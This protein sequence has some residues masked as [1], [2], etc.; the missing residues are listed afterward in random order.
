LHSGSASAL[1]GAT[2]DP[3]PNGDSSLYQTVTIPSSG[4]P[5]LSFWY[6]PTSTDSITYDWQEAQ[7]RNT[8]GTMLA[9]VFKVCSNTQAWTQVTYNLSAY[10]GQ[11]VQI[12]FNVH[13]DGYIDPTSMYLDD[14]SIS[15]GAAASPTSTFTPAPPTA[16]GTP[17]GTAT[18]TPTSTNTPTGGFTNPVANGGF[19]SGLS[20]WTSA[21]VSG[22]GVPASSTYTAHSGSSSASVGVRGPLTAG[23][24]EPNGDNC[25]YQNESFSGS[26]TL[27]FYYKP[28]D[29]NGDTITYDW[30]E[31]YYRASG[32][33]GCGESGTQLFK[34][35][36]NSQVWATINAAVTGPGQIYFNVHED[37]YGDPSAMYVDDVSIH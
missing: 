10:R 6:R 7:I 1:L 19:E 16:T 18:N 35:E 17:T 8:S 13:E 30:Q 9:Q 24:S 27:T 37:G 33:G 34:V 31:G 5:T 11:T 28:Y 4:T 3:E 21:G 2:A 12:Y 32:A 26:H 20:G 14:V 25:L 23:Q 22:L 36:S 15:S 29:V